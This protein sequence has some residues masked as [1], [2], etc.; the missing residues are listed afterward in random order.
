MC[1]R[2]Y[3]NKKS[4][5][6]KNYLQNRGFQPPKTQKITEKTEKYVNSIR[7]QIVRPAKGI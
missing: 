7:G 1:A 4:V 2:S 3:D 6:E 5:N